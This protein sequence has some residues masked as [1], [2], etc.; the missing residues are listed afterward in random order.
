MI[1]FQFR[2]YF[3]DYNTIDYIN[4]RILDNEA[5]FLDLTMLP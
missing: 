5:L 1:Q 3:Y 4:A 2:H